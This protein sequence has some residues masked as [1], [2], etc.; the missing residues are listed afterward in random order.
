MWHLSGLGQGAPI[1]FGVIGNTTVFGAVVLGSSPGGGAKRRDMFISKAKLEKIKNQSW[2]E[3]FDSGRKKAVN[4][5][6][7]VF[8]KLLTKEAALG[9]IDNTQGLNRA[10]EILRKGKQ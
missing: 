10:I 1:P 6:R 9:I 7:K 5:T 2:Q 4:E 3:G 8:L